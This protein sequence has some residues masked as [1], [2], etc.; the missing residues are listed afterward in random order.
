MATSLIHPNSIHLNFCAHVLSATDQMTNKWQ[1]RPMEQWL[2]LIWKWPRL[3]SGH[4]FHE[5]HWRLRRG[6]VFT[7][8][9]LPCNR[10]MGGAGDMV[11]HCTIFTTAALQLSIFIIFKIIIIIAIIFIKGAPFSQ[12]LHSSWKWKQSI[13]GWA[14]YWKIILLREIGLDGRIFIFIYILKTPLI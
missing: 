9:M 14:F 10:F 12:L 11:H 3:H 13:Y 4:S 8:E 7:M 1:P 5:H 2:E 6:A